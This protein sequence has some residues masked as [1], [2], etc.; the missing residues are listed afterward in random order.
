MIIFGTLAAIYTTAQ[1][2]KVSPNRHVNC[3][4]DIPLSYSWLPHRQLVEDPSS[5]IVHNHNPVA[6]DHLTPHYLIV[7]YE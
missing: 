5:R 2:I 4:A 6:N 7:Q 3:I 1:T